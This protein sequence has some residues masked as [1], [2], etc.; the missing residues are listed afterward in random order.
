[1]KTLEITLD[2]TKIAP[3]IKHAHIIENF[4]VLNEGSS[5]V[6]Q[7]DH[8]PKPLYY[9]MLAEYGKV[10]SWEYIEEGPIWWKVRIS[11][12][13]N[14][15]QLLVGEIAA[16]DLQKAAVFKKYGIDF[17][18]GGKKTLKDAC[19]EKQIDIE[20]VKRELRKNSSISTRSLPRFQ[21]W[22]IQFLTQYIIQNHHKYV[23]FSGPTVSQLLEKVVSVHGNH[24]P[25]LIE[26]NQRF[27]NLLTALLSHMQQEEKELFPHIISIEEKTIPLDNLEET[28]SNLVAAFENEHREAGSE[29]EKI[30]SLSQN[31]TVPADACGSYR[32]LYKQLSEFDEDLHQ[33][34]HLENN[35]LFPKVLVLLKG[36]P[37]EIHN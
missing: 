4:V 29:L 27:S 11:K 6:I 28:A 24:H 22:N 33:H 23:T 35:I 3:R 15:E 25:E 12:L 14:E 7:N 5:L 13:T 36:E 18:C 26:I 17:C 30:A 19:A 16:T 20:Q 10:F 8:D 9:Q 34:I 37:K 32:L 31:Y 21:N 1:M 2:V